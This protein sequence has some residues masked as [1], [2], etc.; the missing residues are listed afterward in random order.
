MTTMQ[1]EEA[2]SA[3]TKNWKLMKIECTHEWDDPTCCC[4]LEAMIERRKIRERIS[5]LTGINV[6]SLTNLLEQVIEKYD[7][8]CAELKW[9]CEYILGDT[10]EE[11]E[12]AKWKAN[13]V[14]KRLGTSDPR[15]EL[16]RYTEP[17][18]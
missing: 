18:S 13:N 6:Y 7:E 11:K 10:N 15:R 1:Y 3:L 4:A 12:H 16:Y 14:S 9:A 8:V 5:E 2:L 17:G